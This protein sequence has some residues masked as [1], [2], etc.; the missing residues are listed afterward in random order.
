MQASKALKRTCVKKHTNP[1]LTRH[2][3]IVLAMPPPH[4]PFGSRVGPPGVQEVTQARAFVFATSART[5]SQSIRVCRAWAP[6]RTRHPRNCRRTWRLGLQK[7]GQSRGS[8]AI[9]A[10][11]TLGCNLLLLLELRGTPSLLE[12][13]RGGGRAQ[14]EKGGVCRSNPRATRF[15]ELSRVCKGRSARFCSFLLQAAN[16]GLLGLLA[17]GLTPAPK[18]QTRSWVDCYLFMNL[19]SFAPQAPKAEALTATSEVVDMGPCIPKA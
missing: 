11:V 3:S 7:C 19:N 9:V 14:K 5:R 8:C 16:I 15:D 10:T 13:G 12:L 4:P 2:A 1:L 17:L 6:G 18:L